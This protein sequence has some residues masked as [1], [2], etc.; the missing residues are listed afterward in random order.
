MSGCRPK[1][2]M[3]LVE[4]VIAGAEFAPSLD[5]RSQPQLRSEK[6]TGARPNLN[7]KAA[8]ASV[9]LAG[10]FDRSACWCAIHMPQR[11]LNELCKCVTL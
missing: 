2:P 10:R 1:F 7:R 6:N 9:R 3:L 4:E 11:N 8:S 5:S